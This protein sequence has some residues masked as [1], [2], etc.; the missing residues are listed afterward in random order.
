MTQMTMKDLYALLV[1][2][3][4]NRDPFDLPIPAAHWVMD[5]DSYMQIR[6]AAREGMPH[7]DELDDESK[8]VPD[9]RDQLFAV[10][11]EVRED[12][13]KPHLEYEARRDF[14]PVPQAAPPVA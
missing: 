9:P 12:G 5:L 4:G 7:D 11:V 3:Y 2:E 14:G 6:R 13:G 10:P 8:W 1:K